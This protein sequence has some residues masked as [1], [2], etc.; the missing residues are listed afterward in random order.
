MPV[1]KLVS[2]VIPVYKP[3]KKILEKIEKRLKEQTIPNEI[4]KVE[5][6]PEAV[7]MNK[8]IKKANGEIVITLAQDCL[9]ERK[10]WIEKLISPLK[11]RDFV[12]SVSDLLVPKFFWEKYP[13]LTKVLTIKD[14]FVRRPTMDSRACA[15]RKKDLIELGGFNE[16]PKVIAIDFDLKEKLLKI[17][18]IAY[19]NVHVYHLHKLDNSKKI[20]LDLNY[21]IANG[22]VMREK[23]TSESFW[24]LRLFRA[25]PILGWLSILAV[26][27][28]KKRA[29]PYLPFFL[30]FSIL[31]HLI[32]IYGTARGFIFYKEKSSRNTLVLNPN[33]NPSQT[34]P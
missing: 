11:N 33:K 19:P 4:I 32:Y 7:S 15:Y 20:T 5:N 24:F 14:S 18:K 3:D 13:F 10:D 25:I 12:V 8:G 28:F 26:F 21:A 31:E 1:K 27:P 34:L 30:I 16:D 9:P 2:V 22:K 29:L 17:G 6:N 23:R